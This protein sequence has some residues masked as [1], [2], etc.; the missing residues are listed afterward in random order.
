VQRALFGE[1]VAMS[2]ET[3]RTQ[4]LRS[5][6]TILGVVIGIT[7]LVGMTSLIRGFDQSLRESI[8]TLG[9]DTIFLARFS[10]LSMASGR[11]FTELMRRPNLS[12]ADAAAIERQARSIATVATILGEG[13]PPTQAR[14]SYQGE[15]TKLINILGTSESFPDVFGIDLVAGRF[16]TAGELQHRRRVVVLGQTPLEALFPHVDPIGKRVRIGQ[17]QYTVIG[18][19]GPR[20]VPGGLNVGQN[21]F[22][23]IPHTTYQR[24]F[25]IRLFRMSFGR[26]AVSGEHQSVMIA[27]VPRAGAP[28]AQAIR[29]VEE[30]L[31][32]RHRLTLDEPNDFDL[33]TQEAA[34]RLWEQ[35]SRVVF[36]ALIV[37][38]SIALMVGGIGVMSVMMISVTERTR[39][40][41]TRKALGARRRD[42][43]VQFLLE[44]ALLTAAGGILGIA[45]GSGV[46]F[47]VHQATGFP[48]SLPMWSFALGLGFSASVGLI[49]GLMPAVRASAL[50]PIEALRYE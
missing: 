6:L 2:V 33:L 39:E 32:I 23:V 14:L 9:P 29:E 25:G 13:G 15:H 34:L 20:P 7:S 36:L 26:S 4:R 46:G 21:D 27:A 8:Q 19:L 37:I 24:Q 35:I 42:I 10:G 30:V 12:P 22:A 17:E 50:D 45:L 11:T 1:I 5:A 3:L 49:F 48:V 47:A 43:L 31:R 44:A 18:V 40:I 28:R 38:S 16:F 41:G